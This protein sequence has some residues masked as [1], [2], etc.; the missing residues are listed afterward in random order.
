[1]EHDLNEKGKDDWIPAPEHF[2]DGDDTIIPIDTDVGSNDKA[3]S[4]FLKFKEFL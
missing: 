1:M 4:Y 3:V 2:R